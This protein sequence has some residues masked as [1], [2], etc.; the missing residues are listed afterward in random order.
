M[1]STLWDMQGSTAPSFTSSLYR[2][3]RPQVPVLEWAGAGLSSP[4]VGVFAV[5]GYGSS[6]QQLEQVEL[7]VLTDA[8]L[9]TVHTVEPECPVGTI[10]C[11]RGCY[12]H[13]E[14]ATGHR[15]G[16][17][18]NLVTEMFPPQS[19]VTVQRVPASQSLVHPVVPGTVVTSV[20]YGGSS[21]VREEYRVPGTP[22]LQL[23]VSGPG[24][25]RVGEEVSLELTVRNPGKTDL[26]V[27]LEVAESAQYQFVR[28][29]G[30]TAGLGGK[31]VT[32]SVERESWRTIL[33][34]VRPYR[35]GRVEVRVSAAA[36]SLLTQSSHTIIVRDT[37]FTQ[38]HHTSTQL[39]L[40]HNSYSLQY[41]TVDPLGDNSITFSVTGDMAGPFIPEELQPGVGVTVA[42]SVPDSLVCR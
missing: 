32:V 12:S 27:V 23:T 40:S 7:A 25:C 14:A 20:V 4:V 24:H 2:A 29:E 3:A 15:A 26:R 33:V 21:V 31:M 36:G 16:L 22:P 34:P 19:P 6:A 1:P 5:Q 38:S 8:Q 9:D 11:H 39:D 42:A 30:E 17:G 28:A 18:R 10:P 41:F 13:C 35:L 37:G